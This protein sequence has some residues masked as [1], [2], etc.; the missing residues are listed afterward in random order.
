[1]RPKYFL[2]ETILFALCLKDF[3]ASCVEHP[4]E[5]REMVTREK[6]KNILNWLFFE[7]P[8]QIFSAS[9]IYLKSKVLIE[10]NGFIKKQ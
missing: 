6:N 7:I 10:L 1:M 3:S 8:I 4:D 9:F 2:K 5:H